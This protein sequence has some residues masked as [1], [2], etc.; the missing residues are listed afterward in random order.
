MALFAH[1]FGELFDDLPVGLANRA[2]IGDHVEISG[3]QVLEQ[4][5][6]F[7]RQIELGLVENMEDDDIVAFE[8]EQ[9][10]AFEDLRRFIQQIG[11]KNDDAAPFDLTGDLFENSA[12]VG[13]SAGPLVFNASTPKA[14]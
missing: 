2:R 9:A 8:A 11:D 1:L 6:A 5:V 4:N 13:F 14:S 3:F 7:K 12:D 10:Q